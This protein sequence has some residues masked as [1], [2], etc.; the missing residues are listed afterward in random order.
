VRGRSMLVF[1]AATVI[2]LTACQTLDPGRPGLPD[3]PRRRGEAPTES[4]QTRMRETFGLPGR[5]TPWY[6]DIE[7]VRVVGA[8]AQLRTSIAPNAEGENFALPICDAVL[9]ISPRRIQRVVVYGGGAVL[10]RCP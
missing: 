8:T 1:M 9:D 10:D 7:A 3:R 4:L 5:R 6:D 2:G